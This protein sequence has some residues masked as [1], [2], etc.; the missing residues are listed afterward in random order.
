MVCNQRG[1]HNEKSLHCTR[2]WPLPAPTREKAQAAMKT[3]HGQQLKKTKPT[4][5]AAGNCGA[6][7]QLATPGGG[8]QNWSSFKVS[9]SELSLFEVSSC[10]LESPV[11]KACLFFDQAQILPGENSLSPWV[12]C[13]KQPVAKFCTPLPPETCVVPTPRNSDC[14]C[15]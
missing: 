1:H 9:C 6:K 5:P 13:Q 11:H 15:I 4:N 3:L 10:S 8:E 2:E 7:E 14:D 12:I